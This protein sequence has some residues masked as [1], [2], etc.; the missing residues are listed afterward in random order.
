MITS[1]FLDKHFYDKFH[2]LDEEA[3]LKLNKACSDVQVNNV[4]VGLQP[5]CFGLMLL[6]D[7]KSVNYR[8]FYINGLNGLDGRLIDLNIYDPERDTLLIAFSMHL[9]DNYNLDVLEVFNTYQDASRSLFEQLGYLTIT[10]NELLPYKDRKPIIVAKGVK[11]IIIV[12]FLYHSDFYK[13]LFGPLPSILP[14][15]GD[16]F[17]YLMHNSKNNLI[18]IGKSRNPHYREKTL[19]AEEP[20]ITMIAIWKASERLERHLH[21]LYNDKRLRG[22]WF[23]LTFKDLKELK[24]HVSKYIAEDFT[25]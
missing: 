5:H 24:T 18:K 1:E 15:A 7:S 16:R 9:A 12:P 23:K 21:N 14:I 13:F 25:L 20:E 19:Q 3:V 6:D 22:E 10:A 8:I 17:V 4:I 11:D 2:N